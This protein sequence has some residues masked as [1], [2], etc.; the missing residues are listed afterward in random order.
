MNVIYR[1]SD[2]RKLLWNLC[3]IISITS[4]DFML[5]ASKIAN[6]FSYHWLIDGLMI[7]NYFLSRYD[8]H[9]HEIKNKTDTSILVFSNFFPFQRTIPASAITVWKHDVPH[10]HFCP[11]I[12]QLQKISSIITMQVHNHQEIISD[13]IISL[14]LHFIYYTRRELQILSIIL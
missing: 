7:S 6:Q 12:H 4:I 5:N 3:I 13:L 10:S 11:L 8:S 14:A 2:K 1:T 9:N